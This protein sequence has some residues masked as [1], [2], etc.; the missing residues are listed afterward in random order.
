M[1]TLTRGTS[2]CFSVSSPKDVILTGWVSSEAF[3]LLL[4]TRVCVYSSYYYNSIT[5]LIFCTVMRGD[6]DN[7]YGRGK[8]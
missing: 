3:A 7:Y 5:L 2:N 8:E 4:L 6:K 1:D